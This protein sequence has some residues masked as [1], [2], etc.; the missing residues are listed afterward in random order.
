MAKQDSD[1][2]SLARQFPALGALLAVET[3]GPN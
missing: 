3:P 2:I 1:F